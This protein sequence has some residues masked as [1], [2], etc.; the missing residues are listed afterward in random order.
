MT[1]R[2]ESAAGPYDVHIER[3]ALGRLGS[4]TDGSHRVAIIYPAPLAHLAHSAADGVERP[5]LI[6]VPDAESAKTPEVLAHCWT[7]LAEAGFTRSDIVVGIGGGTTT[8]LAGFVAASWLRGVKY[9]SVPTSV[10]GMVDAAVGGKTGINLQA[11]KNLVGA[12]YEPVEVLCDLEVLTSL[13]PPEVA[14]GLA[15]VV[16]CG[17]IADPVI[18]DLAHEDLADAT[19]V[20]SDRFAELVRRAVQVKATVVA[21]DF[22]ESTSEGRNVGREA[23]NYGHT[24]GHAIE[25]HA[26]YTWRH[27]QAIAVGMA[28]MARVSRDRLGLSS[29]VVALHDDLLGGLGLPRRADA[30]YDELRPIMSLDK[31]ARGNTLR[32]VGI[33]EIG[34]PVIIDDAP[35]DDLRR[36]FDE[37]G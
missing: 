35:E 26:N 33:E 15:E 14:S 34:V 13:A 20:T 24:L 11:G 27:G 9:V 28:W 1:I 30:S 23:L 4:L 2:V 8:D 16:K 19:D 25:A 5:T 6:E 31:K 29:D 37:L 36:A 18:L 12:F 21:A 3:G 22:R 32:L 10:L 17:F 7:A